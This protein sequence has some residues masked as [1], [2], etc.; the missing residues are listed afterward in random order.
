[1]FTAY[2]VSVN[3][4]RVISSVFSGLFQSMGFRSL[5]GRGVVGAFVV[6]V[7]AAAMV[8]VPVVDRAVAVGPGLSVVKSATPATVSRAGERV[9]Y[10]FVV[11]NTGDVA[12]SDVRVVDDMAGSA[13]TVTCPTVGQ[14]VAPGG[15]LTCTGSYVVTQADVDRGRVT[16]TA[17]ASGQAPTPAGGTAPARTVSEGSSAGVVTIASAPGLSVTKSL[18]RTTVGR[19]GDRV[20][21]SFVVTNTGNVTM[22]DIQV[23]DDLSLPGGGLTVTCPTAGQPLAPGGTLTCT[24]SYVMTQADID[25]VGDGGRIVS[26]A[27]A[28]GQAPT[29]TGGTAPARTVSRWTNGGTGIE[30]RVGP[31]LSVV[32]SA[33][34]ATV[35][36][37]G[38]RVSYS[39]AVLNTGSVNLS[40]IRVVDD[41]AGSALAV[42]CPA[43]G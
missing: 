1:M 43:A 32:K 3:S 12:L 14:P 39:F 20:S 36:R 16:S 38:E 15:T 9:S 4:S 34:P 35:S 24:G 22:S 21:Y 37:A 42:T 40:D 5:W 41:M 31:R 2:C 7:V 19:V 26:S 10:S 25:A 6:V 8:V 17:V 23:G 33:T 30:F 28:S 27:R 13:L 18:N 11:T 29:P